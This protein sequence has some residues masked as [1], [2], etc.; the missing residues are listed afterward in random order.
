MYVI[1]I[2]FRVYTLLKLTA[3]VPEHQWLEDEMSFWDTVVYFQ[4]RTVSFR[5]ANMLLAKSWNIELRHF[6]RRCFLLKIQS[7]IFQ[8]P[9][10]RRYLQDGPLP[11]INGV[12]TPINGFING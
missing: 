4:R 9:K 12:I 6:H 2:I 1:S 11:V 10:L 3:R 7:A 8:T 5:E